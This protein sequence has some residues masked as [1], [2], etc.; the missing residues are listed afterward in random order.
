MRFAEN[1]IAV[2]VGWQV[3]AIHK[4]PLDLG[5]VGLFEFAPLPI[6]ALPAGHLADRIPRRL[7]ASISLGVL[8][9]VAIGLLLVSANGASKTWPFFLL[10]PFAETTTR[11]TQRPA[12]RARSKPGDGAGSGRRG[13]AGSARIG[14]GANWNRPTS[15]RSSGFLWIASEPP[16]R[17][18]PRL[19]SAKRMRGSPTSRNAKSRSCSAGGLSHAS[20]LATAPGPAPRMADEARRREARAAGRAPR[21]DAAPGQGRDRCA[22]SRGEATPASGSTSGC[23]TRL[24]R[25][26]R[27]LHPAQEV[28]LRMRDRRPWALAVVTGYGAIFGARSCVF[29]PVSLLR[30]V[31]C[32][33]S[34]PRRTKTL[35]PKIAP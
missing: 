11:S 32:R 19:F 7:Q 5:L 21:G 2:A 33:R 20:N 9:V 25:R 26:A 31:S 29:S 16:S 4:N 23:S 15:P 30:R 17:P 27:P 18:R 34:S 13:P 1:M 3:Y 12:P 22:A 28:E 35:R 24:V 8:V 14:S 10:A 6:L